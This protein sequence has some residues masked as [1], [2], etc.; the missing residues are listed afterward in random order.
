[1]TIAPVHM[2]VVKRVHMQAQMLPRTIAFCILVSLL[3]DIAPLLPPCCF[4]KGN[5]T[6]W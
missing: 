2:R 5:S 1:M 6:T 3:F 4:L